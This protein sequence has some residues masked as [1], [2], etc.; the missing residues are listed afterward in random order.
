MF[1]YI[2][3]ILL[4]SR[5]PAPSRCCLARLPA[6]ILSFFFLRWCRAGQYILQDKTI[7]S[8]LLVHRLRTTS[9][10]RTSSRQQ[11][12]SASTKRK[13]RTAPCLAR[14]KPHAGFTARLGTRSARRHPKGFHWSPPRRL[15]WASSSQPLRR[16]RAQETCNG[17]LLFAN[18]K[19]LP[20]ALPPTVSGSGCPGIARRSRAFRLYPSLSWPFPSDP[21]CPA[22]RRGRL[23]GGGDC[24]AAAAATARRRRL[25]GGGAA[26][27]TQLRRASRRAIAAV[28]RRSF[29]GSASAG[30]GLEPRHRRQGAQASA[31]STRDRPQENVPPSAGR[32]I[33][34]APRR[35]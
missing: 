30:P 8:S 31:S 26:A 4:W 17:S 18:I 12:S 27:V 34:L 29:Q 24:A 16:A 14:C 21:S 5:P 11:S 20:V 1:L 9:N 25:R 10:Q 3:C 19:L 23:R 28:A 7:L 35:Q 2:Y 15:F 13:S 33:A 32:D 22:W 6:T